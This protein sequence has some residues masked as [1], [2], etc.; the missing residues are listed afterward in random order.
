MTEA[1]LAVMSEQVARL[2]EQVAAMSDR[3]AQF[4]LAVTAS[5]AR[6]KRQLAAFADSVVSRARA[7]RGRAE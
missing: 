6:F 3:A 7:D 5:E 2:H 4:A 1:D